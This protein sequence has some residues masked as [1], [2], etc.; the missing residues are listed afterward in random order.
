MSEQDTATGFMAQRDG[1]GYLNQKFIKWLQDFLYELLCG[2][3][4][5]YRKTLDEIARPGL[6]ADVERLM[7]LANLPDFRKIITTLDHEYIIKLSP[8]FYAM[9]ESDPDTFKVEPEPERDDA[10]FKK[11]A[12]DK[13]HEIFTGIVVPI[14]EDRFYPLS[15]YRKFYD[16]LVENIGSVKGTFHGF[17]KS[18]ADVPP[19]EINIDNPRFACLV[20]PLRKIYKKNKSEKTD[21]IANITAEKIFVRSFPI[22][23]SSKINSDEF[24]QKVFRCLSHWLKKGQTALSSERLANLLK[25]DK[26]EFEEWANQCDFLISRDSKSK[27]NIKYYGLKKLTHGIPGSVIDNLSFQDKV[28]EYFEQEHLNGYLF[29]FATDDLERFTCNPNILQYDLSKCIDFRKLGV[30]CKE[31]EVFATRKQNVIKSAYVE[32]YFIYYHPN[33]YGIDTFFKLCDFVKSNGASV[34]HDVICD[35]F[36]FPLGTYKQWLSYIGKYNY[37]YSNFDASIQKDKTNIYS[38][39]E[40]KFLHKTFHKKILEG[41]SEDMAKDTQVTPISTQPPIPFDDEKFEAAVVQILTSG[42]LWRSSETISA[43]GGWD[44]EKLEAC[45]DKNVS[46]IKKP[47]KEVGKCYY[48]LLTRLVEKTAVTTPET[49]TIVVEAPEKKDEVVKDEKK[50]FSSPHTYEVMAFA[51]LRRIGDE[52]VR[53]MNFYGNR[54]AIHHSEPFSHFTTAQKHLMSGITLLQKELKI[55]DGQLPKSEDI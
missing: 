6:A 38:E 5:E 55:K 13:L 21:S 36:K 14:K 1:N 50:A 7:R 25:I 10:K 26:R 2:N 43:T 34:L 8:I 4:T 19:C 39:Y 23:T 15:C 44:K 49:S 29:L 42:S 22:E 12:N 35:R 3:N 40:D 18:L 32:G 37:F 53:V 47:S 17:F 52:L 27:E 16:E 45:L 24:G 9:F 51:M 54:I 30:S 28:I 33:S 46:F 11:W 31:F 20:E 41:E 48:A